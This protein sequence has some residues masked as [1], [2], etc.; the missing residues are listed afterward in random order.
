[1]THLI[2]FIT[3]KEKKAIGSC[4]KRWKGSVVDFLMT[5]QTCDSMHRLG[6]SPALLSVTV[7]LQ[8]AN[9]FPLRH[10]VLRSFALARLF[11]QWHCSVAGI[12]RETTSQREGARDAAGATRLDASA[13]VQAFERDTRAETWAFKV[14]PVPLSFTLRRFWLKNAFAFKN[15]AI[16]FCASVLLRKSRYSGN[17]RQFVR[18]DAWAVC[19]NC[20]SNLVVVKNSVI[21][22]CCTALV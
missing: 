9:K 3:I 21:A 20:V 8:S 4:S 2:M 17:G 11:S 7:C 12:K 18:N 19:K 10:C 1:M 6:L 16:E 22:F 14:N 5:H 15:E 13:G